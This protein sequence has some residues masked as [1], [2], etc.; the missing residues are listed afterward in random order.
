MTN[1]IGT[2]RDAVV[3]ALREELAR[4]PL[5]LVMGQD[6][7]R[8]GGNFSTTT[9]LYEQFG[10]KRVRDTPISEDA[11]VGIALGAGI[12]GYRPVAEIMFSSFLGCAM[13]ELWN[14]VSQLHYI[15]NGLCVPRLTIRTVNV[16]GRSSG[17][18][19]SG[20]PE[21]TLAH[22]PGLVVVAPATPWDTKAML[23]A[24]IRSDDPVIFIEN[25]MLYGIEG[26][27]GGEEDLVG[28]ASARIVR[29]GDDITLVGYSGTVRIIETAATALAARE[30]SAEVIDLRSLAPLDRQM[31]L[32][33]VERTGR[34]LVVEED[35]RTCGFGAEVIATVTEELW[36][37]LK[38]PP[39][40]IAAADTPVPFAPVLE[41]AIAPRTS[42]VIAA[43]LRLTTA[44]QAAKA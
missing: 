22:I 17:G 21:A 12:G 1:H 18:H 39:V 44:R 2:C 42:D 29:P 13:D 20:R 3:Q 27:I 14:H 41:E 9:G 28:F 36:P 11:I 32:S 7:G 24:A 33:S 25:A 37:S 4:D 30:V 43:A 19:H 6:V 31:I 16:F 40:R 38:A 8:M 5:T 23:K 34:V 26:P 35:S 15:S 10:P